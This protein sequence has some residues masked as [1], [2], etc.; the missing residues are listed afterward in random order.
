M[1]DYYKILEVEENASDEDIKKSYRNL[2][3]KYHPDL[4]PEGAEKFK[5][6][7]EAYETLSDKGKREMYN[8]KK[9]NPYSNT[10]FENLFSQMF[11]GNPNFS[12]QR[13]KQAPD[14][15]IKL[16]ISPVESFIGGER[17]VQYNRENGCV[18]C[19]GSGGEQQL[20]GSCGGSGAQIKTF[21]TGFM[22]QQIRTACPSC[23]GR[24]YTLI[25]K[26]FTCDGRGSRNSVHEIKLKLPEGIDNGQYLRLNGLGDFK[27][28]EYGD[29]IIQIEVQ[30]K[31]GYEKID[32]DLIYNLV[33][34]IDEIQKDKFLIPHPDGNLS[35]DAPRIIDTTKPLRLRGKGF[36]GGDFYVKLN[37]RFERPI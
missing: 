21:G 9:N 2:S 7:A 11:G 8:Q 15:I 35:I 29:L 4:N 1:K 26:C 33:L 16:K 6:I 32:N 25:H 23:A 24:G 18:N 22:V 34:N 19:N 30:P 13:R 31:D 27:M 10:P 12:Q 14:K 3:K 36:K 37:L 5:E 20:C 17:L 28:G